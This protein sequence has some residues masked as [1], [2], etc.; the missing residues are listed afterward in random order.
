MFFI[1]VPESVDPDYFKPINKS[2]ALA[3]LNL[4]FD[5]KDN[6]IVFTYIGRLAKVKGLPLIIDAFK[7]F[8]KIEANSYLLIAGMGEL[9]MK[10]SKYI[11]SNNLDKKVL[12]LGNMD[13]EK[14]IS[15]INISNAC[16]FGSFVEGFSISMLEILACGKPIVST[17]VSGTDELIVPGKTGIV[18]NSRNPKAYCE[19][20]Q[21]VIHFK[22]CTDCRNLVLNR[23][24]TVK[25]WRS[26][27]EYFK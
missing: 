16:L 25:Q 2:D 11:L 13:S 24:S 3:N 26:I 17:N 6:D 15:L 22:N 9:K 14:V 18:V 27:L 4:N 19:A 20:M 23:Y 12:L 7:E 8:Q 5:I 21:Q 10:I 1:Q